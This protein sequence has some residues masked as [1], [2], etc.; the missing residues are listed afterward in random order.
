MDKA[1]ETKYIYS[2]WKE[3][4][5]KQQPKGY[6]EQHRQTSLPWLSCT[7][8]SPFQVKALINST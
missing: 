5:H 3:A 7:L 6:S 2:E 4:K 8:A 1:S